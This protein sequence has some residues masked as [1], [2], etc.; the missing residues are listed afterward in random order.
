MR[1][2]ESTLSYTSVKKYILS[3]IEHFKSLFHKINLNRAAS[4]LADI[5]ELRKAV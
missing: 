1:N 4:Y 3:I 2:T 5:K